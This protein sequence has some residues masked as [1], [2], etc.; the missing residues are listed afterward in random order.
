MEHDV[1]RPNFSLVV[2]V[3]AAA[4]TFVLMMACFPGLREDIFGPQA[5]GELNTV[6]VPNGGTIEFDPIE[7]GET[8]DGDVGLAIIG[9]LKNGTDECRVVVL[10]GEPDN[11]R[12][13]V[14]G[15]RSTGEFS[16][17]VTPIGSDTGTTNIELAL[18]V[19]DANCGAAIAIL[20]RD[21]GIS[22]QDPPAECHVQQLLPIQAV[23]TVVG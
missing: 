15:V 6:V 1:F 19:G 22:F 10:V 3:A 2:A 7:R 8:V 16:V 4:L 23:R 12:T 18:V 17:P 21:G 20:E 13:Y 11:N 9:E 14:A 5:C